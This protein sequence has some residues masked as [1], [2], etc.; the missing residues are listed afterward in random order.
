[1][2]CGELIARTGYEN[3]AVTQLRK[4]T[5]GKCRQVRVRKDNALPWCAEYGLDML[6]HDRS[7]I[8]GIPRCSLIGDFKQEHVDAGWT[9]TIRNIFVYESDAQA[10]ADMLNGEIEEWCADERKLNKIADQ[11][12]Q[13]YSAIFPTTAPR[14]G[15]RP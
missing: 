11:E 4:C 10:V 15:F 12:Y 7:C 5:V 6:F 8:G 3:Y 2:T 9:Q 1:M 14:P 13:G